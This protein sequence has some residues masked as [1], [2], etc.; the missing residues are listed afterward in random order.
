MSSLF[1]GESR[2]G[3]GTFLKESLDLGKVGGV[4]DETGKLLSHGLLSKLVV[5]IELLPELLLSRHGSG[6]SELNSGKVEVVK[7]THGSLIT[8]IVLQMGKLAGFGKDE[9]AEGWV[10]DTTDELN[11]LLGVALADLTVV[12]LLSEVHLEDVLAVVLPHTLEVGLFREAR[13]HLV[14]HNHILLLDDLRSHL[15]KSLILSLESLSTFR[16]TGIQ[17]EKNVLILVS[18]GEA[19][20]DAIT[21]RL[22]VSLEQVTLVALPGHHGDFVVEET[23]A[24]ATHPVLHSEPLEGVG[25][26]TLTRENLGGKLGLNVVH[27]VHPGL[28]RVGID[29]PAVLVL[30]L[31]PVGDAEALEDSSGTTVEGDISDTLKDG[32]WVE[33]LSVDVMHDIRLLVE[34][35]TIDILN[36]ETYII[37]KIKVKHAHSGKHDSQSR[38][39]SPLLAWSEWLS[40]L[41]VS[42]KSTVLTL[43]HPLDKVFGAFYSF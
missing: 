24:V 42:A 12:D 19:V 5:A 35:V 16:G 15:A 4:S 21:L 41:A 22:S 38:G 26:L 3:V 32:V 8:L 43:D 11:K 37:I 25:L 7:D 10:V 18:V 29:I 27:G 33:I 30:V 39:Y 13:C 23:V 1:C 14:G 40:K 9:K 6:L 34:L 2:G 36:T 17:A 28:T 31:G 20:K